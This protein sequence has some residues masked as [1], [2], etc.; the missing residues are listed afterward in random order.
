MI[1]DETQLKWWYHDRISV[2]HLLEEVLGRFAA[3]CSTHTYKIMAVTLKETH[4]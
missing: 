2:I 4:I 1:L 3:Q